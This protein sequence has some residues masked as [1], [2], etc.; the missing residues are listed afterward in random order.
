MTNERDI[1][2]ECKRLI[3]E[4]LHDE[5][6]NLLSQV[7]AVTPSHELLYQRGEQ[8]EYLGEFEKALDDFSSALLLEPNE[9]NYLQAR[10]VLLSSRL[11][12]AE[13]SL[14]DFSKAASLDPSSAVPHK[15]LSISHLLL[16]NLASAYDHAERAIDLDDSDGFSHYCLG[17]CLL[18]EKRFHSARTEFEIALKLGPQSAR[19]WNGLSSACLGTG[20]LDKAELYCQNGINLEASAMSYLSLARIQ[21]D[22]ANPQGAIESLETAKTF[23]LGYAEQVLLDG[24]L[25]RANDQLNDSTEE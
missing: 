14:D 5:A 25:N 24:Y 7:I 10:G 13:E 11:G 18:A 23:N 2:N 16:G 12:R 4:Q 6:V 22:R 8:Y 9:T 3:K 1:L 20:E 17:R 21:L 15:H 19:F